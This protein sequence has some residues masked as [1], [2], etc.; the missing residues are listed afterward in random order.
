M[1]KRFEPVSVA[2]QSV[3]N[4]LNTG[5]APPSPAR[6]VAIRPYDFDTFSTLTAE[7][8]HYA[9]T[10][11]DSGHRMDIEHVLVLVGITLAAL[12]SSIGFYW[13][14]RI[15]IKKSTRKV[16]YYLLE[17]RYAI[18]TSLINPDHTYSKYIQDISV[19]MKK[20]DMDLDIDELNKLMA[21]VIMKHLTDINSTVKTDIDEKV[22]APYETALLELATINPVLA[23]Q[24]KGKEK[25]QELLNHNKNYISHL[26]SEILPNLLSNFEHGK[27]A[28]AELGISRHEKSIKELTAELDGEILKVSISCSL[29][30]YLRCR[31]ALKHSPLNMSTIDT[32]GLSDFLDKCIDA[33]KHAAITQQAE[34]QRQQT[35]LPKER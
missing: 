27:Q 31:R 15:E 32:S 29:V 3:P 7:Q 13:R 33:L 16:L 30:D 10:K 8:W 34:G 1:K 2:C 12:L 35:Q 23:Y 24:L 4:P 9:N 19:E 21:P 17:I 22:L 18:H 11:Q 6:S 26:N 14:N 5:F 20:R 25:L 28:L